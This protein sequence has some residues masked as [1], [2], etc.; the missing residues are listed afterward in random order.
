[1]QNMRIASYKITKGTFSDVVDVAKEGMLKTFRDQPGFL[2]Y[3][4]ADTGDQ[5]CVSISIWESRAQAESASLVS[6]AWV[7]EHL[8]DRVELVSTKIGDLAFFE[9]VPATV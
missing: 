6:S 3:G 5:T 7:L 4:L 8:S 2:R 1:M 9:G